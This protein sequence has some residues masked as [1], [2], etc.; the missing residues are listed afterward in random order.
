MTQY[1]LINE[2]HGNEIIQELEDGLN[3]KLNDIVA[4]PAEAE[5]IGNISHTNIDKLEQQLTNEFEQNYENLSNCQTY[6]N[7][8]LNEWLNYYACL[9]PEEVLFCLLGLDINHIP[10]K[11]SIEK[12]HSEIDCQII[13]AVTSRTLEYEALRRAIKAKEKIGMNLP[14]RDIYTDGLINWAIDKFIEEV[15]EDNPT[16]KNMPTKK[17]NPPNV[18]NYPEDFAKELHNQLTAH[19]LISGEFDDM[20]TWIPDTNNSLKYLCDELYSKF[21]KI[22]PKNGKFINVTAYI[23]KPHASDLRKASY[24]TTG[25]VLENIDSSLSI[26]EEKYTK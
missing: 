25:N 6:K 23:N 16:V 24:I 10:S 13:D 15:T 22:V 2:N 21:E 14:G 9:T 4:I 11:F 19:E 7:K 1:K 8:Q 20:W 26:L 18:R 5:E 12:M 17:V 3:S